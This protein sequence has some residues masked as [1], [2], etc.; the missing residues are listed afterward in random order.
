MEDY[1]VD[2]NVGQYLKD[3]GRLQASRILIPSCNFI[4]MGYC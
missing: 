2:P 1:R 4:L 3:V